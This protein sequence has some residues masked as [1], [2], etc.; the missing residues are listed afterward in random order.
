MLVALN[1]TE[2]NSC[3]LLNM[4]KSLALVLFCSIVIHRHQWFLAVIMT[5]A[6]TLLLR[7]H[8]LRQTTD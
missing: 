7:M 6:L 8:A 1:T 2:T 3:N 4:I 5:F